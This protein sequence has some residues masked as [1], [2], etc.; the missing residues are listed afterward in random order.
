M[1]ASTMSC[2]LIAWPRIWLRGKSW[3]GCR[4]GW[5]SGRGRLGGRSILGDARNT[6]M[7]SVMNLKI[8]YRE[9]FRPFAPSV[10]RERV[11]D[12]FEMETDSPYMLLVAPVVEKRRIPLPQ[13]QTRLLG[14]RSA[15]CPAVRYSRRHA[16]GL[17]GPHPD[18]SRGDQSPVLRLLKAFEDADR[19]CR[20]SSTR[21]L[22]FVGSRSCARRRMRIGVSCGQKWM[23]WCWRTAFCTN[24]NKNLS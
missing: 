3:D 15:E 14:N 18:R 7:Q 1:N 13:G 4:V 16:S 5:S 19:L 2:S 10:L 23:C 17:F 20:V 22:M 11:S 21:R 6:K 8:K 24:R 12:Y 9:S